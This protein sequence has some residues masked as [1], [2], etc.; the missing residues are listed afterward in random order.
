MTYQHHAK[1]YIT[2]NIPIIDKPPNTNEAITIPKYFVF[3]K[4]V[5]KLYC[6][7]VAT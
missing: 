7:F 4:T 5:P 6:V 3:L 1:T 2:T